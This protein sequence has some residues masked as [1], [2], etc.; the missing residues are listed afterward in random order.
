MHCAACQRRGTRISCR[1]SQLRLS[2]RSCTLHSLSL[3]DKPR[4]GPAPHPRRAPTDMQMH[5]TT[6]STAVSRRGTHSLPRR[7]CQPAGVRRLQCAASGPQHDEPPATSL[8]NIDA[9]LGVAEGELQCTQPLPTA[10]AGYAT[11]PHRR[12]VHAASAAIHP[13]RDPA[14]YTRLSPCQPLPALVHLQTCSRTP[15]S[16]W[17]PGGSLNPSSRHHPAKP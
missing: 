7:A 8:D 1:L 5:S 16:S 4:P 15:T 10:D 17:C 3:P 13:S 14:S 2:A 12:R 11:A 6:S 9:L